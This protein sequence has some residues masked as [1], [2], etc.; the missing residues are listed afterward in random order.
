MLIISSVT[1]LGIGDRIPGSFI[2]KDAE[3]YKLFPGEY[4][5]NPPESVGFIIENGGVPLNPSGGL[6]VHTVT[7]GNSGR[8]YFAVTSTTE[9]ENLT[10]IPGQNSLEKPVI[11]EVAAVQPIYIGQGSPLNRIDITGKSVEFILHG[12]G[13]GYTIGGDNP[14]EVNYLFFGNK[15]QGWREGLPFKFYAFIEDDILKIIPCDRQWTGGRPVLESPDPRDHCPAINTWYY[16]YNQNIFASNLNDPKIIPN[17]TE[18]QLL[19]ILDWVQDELG[20][21]T[22]RTYLTGTSMG[23]SGCI[24][25]A[26]HHP[27]KFALVYARVPAVAYLPDANLNR[28]ECFCG[29]LDASASNHL[30]EPFID[31]LNAILQVNKV[32]TNLPHIIMLSGRLDQSIAWINNPPFY[33]AMNA[34]RQGLTAF[35]SERGHAD[36]DNNFSE[37]NF[38]PPRKRFSLDESYLVITNCSDNG[39]PGNGAPLDG[40]ERGWINR[41]FDWK[42]IVDSPEEYA[43][44][45]LAYFCTC[46]YDYRSISLGFG[47]CTRCDGGNFKSTDEF[48]SAGF[49]IQCVL[50]AGRIDVW[51]GNQL[52]RII[53]CLW[54]QYGACCSNG[55]PGSII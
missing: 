46:R 55:F 40:D 33:H 12:R 7:P 47:G 34:A 6:F 2:S 19:G 51:D 9:H 22:N 26:I 25:L 10:I 43:V 50:G 49:G 52:C 27:E 15:K 1:A 21:D 39:N 36:F 8:C 17:Y 54:Y 28:L 11:S 14:Q 29:P 3:N 41:G 48:Y 37:K 23:G 44:T 20:A 5:E 45:I 18:E 32:K 53:N 13:G 4:A 24:S 35:W 42:D 38:A 30:G 31:H 16:G